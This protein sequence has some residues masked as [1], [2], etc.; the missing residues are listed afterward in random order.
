MRQVNWAYKV[1]V[2]PDG[3]FTYDA[4]DVA[5]ITGLAAGEV[6]YDH[7]TYSTDNGERRTTCSL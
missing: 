4:S 1:E 2:Q 6:L 3:S 7:F 5:V